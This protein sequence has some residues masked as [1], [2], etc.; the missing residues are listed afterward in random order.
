MTR[1]HFVC[2]SFSWIR[3]IFF[4]F[5]QHRRLISIWPKG[6]AAASMLTMSITIQFS[7]LMSHAFGWFCKNLLPEN[8]IRKFPY[9]EFMCVCVCEWFWVKEKHGIRPFWNMVN[10]GDELELNRFNVNKLYDDFFRLKMLK[11]F[12][13]F[14]RGR[15]WEKAF[16]YTQTNALLWCE[17][18]YFLL[19]FD[20]RPN[21]DLVHSTT[22]GYAISWDRQHSPAPMSVFDIFRIRL[23]CTLRYS[24]HSFFDRGKNPRSVCS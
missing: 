8:G 15:T 2:L 18:M 7:I 4:F 19:L 12:S 22:V 13:A 21:V 1:F 10:V 14:F 11:K 9:I 24:N 5:I 3:H 23:H 6:A 17:L 16:S 20:L